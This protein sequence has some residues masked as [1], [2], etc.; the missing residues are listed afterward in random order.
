MRCG[1]EGLELKG[2]LSLAQGVAEMRTRMTR[3]V[4]VLLL[5]FGL[6]QVALARRTRVEGWL[7]LRGHRA[8]EY[9]KNTASHCI[10]VDQG[11]L[12]F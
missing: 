12:S 7:A 9:V 2:I 4:G 10:R 6:C 1:V 3:F 11:E 8:H 5:R